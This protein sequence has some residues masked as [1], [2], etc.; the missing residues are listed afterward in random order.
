MRRASMSGRAGSPRSCHFRQV[1]A[2]AHRAPVRRHA[3]PGKVHRIRRQASPYW[4]PPA[5]PPDAACAPA[6]PRLDLVAPARRNGARRPL[7]P[8]LPQTVYTCAASGAGGPVQHP[9]RVPPST[10]RDPSQPGADPSLPRAA[11]VRRARAPAEP[12]RISHS[13]THDTGRP[14][15]RPPRARSARPRDGPPGR[16]RGSAASYRWVRTT[17]RCGHRY[18]RPARIPSDAVGFSVKLF[19]RVRLRYLT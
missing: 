3:A 1:L 8:R 9:G 15:H 5:R 4:P 11:W 7:V 2:P 18:R 13:P 16:A 14:V 10:G 12:A 6:V 19:T 17:S